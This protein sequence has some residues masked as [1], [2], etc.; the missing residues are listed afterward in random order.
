[1]LKCAVGI[2]TIVLLDASVKVNDVKINIA[3]THLII[4]YFSSN[5]MNYVY[6]QYISNAESSIQ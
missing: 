1:V 5:G 3:S 2:A 6:V 4:Q